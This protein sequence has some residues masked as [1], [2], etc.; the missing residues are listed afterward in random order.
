[1]YAIFKRGSRQYRVEE[2][3]MIDMDLLADTKQGDKV[4]FGEV[5]FTSDGSK[6]QVGKPSIA[7]F[8]VFGEVV[9]T[10][11]GEKIT[12]LKYKRSHTQCRKWGHRQQ[13]TR[14]KITGIGKKGKEG[15]HGT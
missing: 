10:V 6:T 11:K 12:T 3:D 15:K 5:I 9:G 1:M 4:E 2:G 13:Y 14:V 7:N 8:Q